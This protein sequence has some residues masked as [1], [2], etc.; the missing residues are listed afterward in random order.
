MEP[1]S[2]ISDAMIQNIIDGVSESVIETIACTFP[3]LSSVQMAMD[4]PAQHHQADTQGLP[5]SAPDSNSDIVQATMTQSTPDGCQTSSLHDSSMLPVIIDS[6]GNAVMHYN[7]SGGAQ[8]MSPADGDSTLPNESTEKSILEQI[9]ALRSSPSVADINGGFPSS[10]ERELLQQS[11]EVL[12]MTQPHEPPSAHPAATPTTPVAVLPDTPSDLL[13][14][15]QH[16]LSSSSPSAVVAQEVQISEEGSNCQL[17]SGSFSSGYQHDGGVVEQGSVEGGERSIA[18]DVHV[19]PICDM[20]T[21]VT[22]PAVENEIVTV[23][24]VLVEGQQTGGS[25][26]H[27]EEELAAIQESCSLADFVQELEQRSGAEVVKPSSS[28]QGKRSKKELA[29]IHKCPECNK[30]FPRINS[31]KRHILL[32]ME[33]RPFQCT[34]C[35]ANYKSQ[36]QL[37][38]HVR[39][40]TGEKPA[41]CDYCHKKFRTY[42]EL[43]CHRRTH[44]GEKPFDCGHCGKAFSSRGQR[45]NHERIH[46]GEKP[47]ECEF[48]GM[49][50]TESSARR[51]HRFTHTGENPHKCAVCGRGFKQAGNLNKHM[52]TAHSGK[53]PH[54]CSECKKGFSTPQELTRHTAR[55]HGS[56]RPH[57]CTICDR[58]YALLTDLTQHKATHAHQCSNCKKKFKNATELENH[59]KEACAAGSKDDSGPS[60]KRPQREEPPRLAASKRS[61]LSSDLSFQPPSS[62]SSSSPPLVEGAPGLITFE[63]LLTVATVLQ[64]REQLQQQQLQSA[65][66]SGR[67]GGDGG[68]HDVLDIN[69]SSQQQAAGKPGVGGEGAEVYLDASNVRPAA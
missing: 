2:E 63:E 13:H 68:G 54:Q 4:M 64:H 12:V 43:Y 23:P 14:H 58:S 25:D 26:V 65:A 6:R 3:S 18:D 62:S 16:V 8:E 41:E 10:L 32:H 27:G 40:H 11:K 39:I 30:Y 69:S 17:Q 55:V 1:E 19:V 53:K 66:S 24:I 35:Q 20:Q 57:K 21:V 15:V 50:F 33:N 9:A 49:R 45:N 44:T 34:H 42:N 38:R 59:L 67:G 52:N 46:T 22:E 36:S 48:C 31:L 7:S 37:Q 29:K 60:R 28:S 5:A 61:K 47:Y 51:V 56:E